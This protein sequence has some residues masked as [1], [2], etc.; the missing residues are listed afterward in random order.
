MQRIRQAVIVVGSSDVDAEPTFAD[1]SRRGSL[2]LVRVAGL[3]LVKRQIL[4]LQRAGVDHVL[5]AGRPGDDALRA[6]LQGDPAFARAGVTVEL[7]ETAAAE[8]TL[9]T[10]LLAVEGRL[11]ERF[12]ATTCE[13]IIDVEVAR[14]AAAAPAAAALWVCVDA[15]GD[16]RAR[17]GDRR[18]RTDGDALARLDGASPDADALDCG[19]YVG[20]HA[21]LACLRAQPDAPGGASL[22]AAARTLGARARVLRVDGALW[23]DVRTP[24]GRACARRRLLGSLSKPTDGA[25][26][27]HINR[28]VSRVVTGWVLDSRVSPNQMTLVANAIGFAGVWIVAQATWTSILVG[29]AL[30]QLQSI[31]DGCDGELARLK[32]AGSKLGEWLD[33]VL[34]DTINIVYGAALGH[35][36]AVL[37][38]A[39]VFRWLGFVTAAGYTISNAVQYVHLWKVHRSG[40]P[41]H[42][43]WWFQTADAYLQQS[44]AGAGVGAQ[45]VG[46]LHAMG[47]RDV[48]LLAFLALC[49][50]RLPHVAVVWYV[51]IATVSAVLAIVHVLAG[52]IRPVGAGPTP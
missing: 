11:A 52:G 12:V 48:F 9:A 20:D 38:D 32:F 37:L 42:F 15:G 45:L 44:L 35:A 29:A 46:V 41:F 19:V 18:L 36:V 28:R 31:L 39:P 14:A 26:A 8:G 43:R 25:V 10:C 49:A 4:T 40:N 23:Q 2:A 51:A 16:A 7:I 24:A 30:V 3:A 22:A 5:V 17:D 47:R 33:N 1:A 13:Q 27:R 34:D 6:A 50:V 21:L